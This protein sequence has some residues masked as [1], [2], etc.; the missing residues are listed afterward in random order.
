MLRTSEWQLPCGAA[1]EVSGVGTAMAQVAAM[2]Q[3]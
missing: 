3:V 2:A 1:D